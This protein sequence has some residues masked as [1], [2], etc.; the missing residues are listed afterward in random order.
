MKTYRKRG[1]A[2][3]GGQLGFSTVSERVADRRLEW[4]RLESVFRLG[5]EC[6]VSWEVLQIFGTKN[7]VC[8]LLSVNKP[9][10]LHEHPKHTLASEIL[11]LLFAFP[12]VILPQSSAQ[13]LLLNSCFC[14][15]MSLKGEPCF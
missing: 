1:R 12:Q 11:N 7:Y 10:G 3:A 4:R 14:S 6:Q 8:P 9:Y 5:P 2:D 15:I 13:T